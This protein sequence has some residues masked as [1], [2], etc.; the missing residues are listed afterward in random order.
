MTVIETDFVPVNSYTTDSLFVGIGQRY[1]VVIDASNVVDNYWFNITFGGSGF[2]GSSNNS[3]PAAIVRYDGAPDANPTDPGETPVDHQCLD[4]QSFTPVV[5]RDVPTSSFVAS[6]NVT[7][8][9]VLTDVAN[10]WTVD[11]SSMDVD[12]NN[13]VAQY[14][15]RDESDWPAS[16]NVLKI[17]ECDEVRQP[18]RWTSL[19]LQLAN[20][21]TTS[22]HIGSSLTTRTQLLAFLTPSTSM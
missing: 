12:W 9:I 4:Y 3:Y 6:A 15:A 5:T 21:F 1:D 20:R 17:D 19:L 7:L 13:P 18:P 2:C 22:G 11:G 8:D 14:V 10:K 16:D